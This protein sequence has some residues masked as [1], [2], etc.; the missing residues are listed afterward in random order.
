M[1]LPRLIAAI[2]EVHTDEI[3]PYLEN[4]RRQICAAC[5]LLD[6]DNC[7]CPLDYL[8]VLVVDAVEA[9]DRRHNPD[10][11]T[12]TSVAERERRVRAARVILTVAAGD[13]K[14]K[15]FTF[16]DRT[17][18]V[19]G[20]AEACHVRFSSEAASKYLSRY[21]CLLD[22]NPPNI[23]VQDLGSR[24]GT[25]VNGRIIG[26]R[27]R[28]D[29]QPDIPAEAYPLSDGDE[30]TLGPV[31][32]QVHITDAPAPEELSPAGRQTH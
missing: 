28:E 29:K 3:A 7:P 1:H 16:D 30:L 23:R 10:C 13:S 14:G 32:L 21:H 9:V 26:G 25:Y 4:T 5:P 22:I 20:R 6:G 11:P 24:N 8:A 17:V 15:E 19:A 12:E 31:V 18:C 2:R 27:Q